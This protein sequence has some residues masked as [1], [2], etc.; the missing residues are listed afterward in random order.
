MGRHYLTK[1]PNKKDK[2]KEKTKHNEKVNEINYD[3][4]DRG[5]RILTN[6]DI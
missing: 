1:Q 6:H 5:A 2:D 4:D 3:N